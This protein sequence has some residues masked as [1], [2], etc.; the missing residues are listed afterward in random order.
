[1]EGLRSAGF[2]LAR[3]KSSEAGWKPAL[4]IKIAPGDFRVSQEA[5][6]S[7]NYKYVRQISED[8]QRFPIPQ[9]AEYA[10]HSRWRHGDVYI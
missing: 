2:Q 8:F 3:G 10:N 7:M 1:M 9:Y 6:K 4:R 5:H